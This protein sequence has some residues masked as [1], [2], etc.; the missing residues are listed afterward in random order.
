MDD[1]L[2]K[3]K[4]WNQWHALGLLLAGMLSII[5]A[6]TT[7]ILCL[8]LASFLWLLGSHIGFLRTYQPFAG[9]ANWVTMFRLT[10]LFILGFF[11]P[12]FSQEQLF[13]LALVIVGL[14]G[15][16]GYLARKFKQSSDLGAYLDME[17]DTFFVCLLCTNYFL[18]AKFGF[19]ILIVGY[20]RYLYVMALHLFSLQ[21]KKEKS[22]KF[23]K[24]IAV[25]LFFALLF[26]LISS[27]QFYYPLVLI[28]SLLV[29]YSFGVSFISLLST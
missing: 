8:C 25:L 26:P 18:E 22:T 20:L 21:N 27:V 15:L 9:Y 16:D 13:V 11:Y 2:F 4:R 10:L 3:I 29:L 14:D 24:T 5:I 7:P 28:A 19:W 12:L 1:L 23:A 6:S 17:C